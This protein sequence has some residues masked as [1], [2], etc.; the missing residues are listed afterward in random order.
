MPV[1]LPSH[2]HCRGTGGRPSL[3]FKFVIK[4]LVTKRAERL[5]AQSLETGAPRACSHQ[6]DFRTEVGGRSVMA[7]TVVGDETRVLR[8]RGFTA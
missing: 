1:L 7:V 3:Y 8:G 5:L 6:G 4:E 2:D